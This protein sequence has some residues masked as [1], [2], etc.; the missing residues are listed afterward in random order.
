[1]NFFQNC[2]FLAI[3]Q[4]FVIF[5]PKPMTQFQTQIMITFRLFRARLS[6]LKNHIFKENDLEFLL[7]IQKTNIWLV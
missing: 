4:V 6:Y 2:E 3:T 5:Q 7:N 1:M